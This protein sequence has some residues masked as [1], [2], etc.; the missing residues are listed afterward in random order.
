MQINYRWVWGSLCFDWFG[1]NRIWKCCHAFLI[2]LC[3]DNS[4]QIPDR[5]QYPSGETRQCKLTL[6]RELKFYLLQKFLS[7]TP[8]HLARGLKQEERV[9]GDGNHPCVVATTRVMAHRR[10]RTRGQR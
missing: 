8:V 3:P 6:R 9:V 4:K 2:A 1:L 5:K 7:G 10:E